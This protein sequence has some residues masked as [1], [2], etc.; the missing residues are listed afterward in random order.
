[1]T[2]RMSS[3]VVVFV[4][5]IMCYIDKDFIYLLDI[6]SIVERGRHRNKCKWEY[7]RRASSSAWNVWSQEARD[8]AQHP[9]KLV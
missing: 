7:G 1:M 9:W 8:R 4:V 2:E 6:C 5:V 3:G